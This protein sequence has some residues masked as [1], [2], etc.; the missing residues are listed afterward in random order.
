MVRRLS[1]LV[2]TVAVL[3]F[4]FTVPRKG[5]SAFSVFRLHPSAPPETAESAELLLGTPPSEEETGLRLLWNE[6]ERNGHP[7]VWLTPATETVLQELSKQNLELGRN[8]DGRI[9]AL[10]LSVR[11]IQGGG[12]PLQPLSLLEHGSGVD[13]VLGAL[14]TSRDILTNETVLASLHAEARTNAYEVLSTILSPAP[15]EDLP[16]D[17]LPIGLDPETTRRIQI[18]SEASIPDARS[19]LFVSACT[20]LLEPER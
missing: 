19:G 14:P 4:L 2:A 18:L 12:K 1:I 20:V 11:S 15:A 17:D 5:M 16:E 8:P 7:N 9:V 13:A 3:C 6:D 10:G